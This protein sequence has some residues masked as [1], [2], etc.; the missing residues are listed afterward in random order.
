MWIYPNLKRLFSDIWIHLGNCIVMYARINAQ[1][2]NSSWYEETSG[3]V[4]NNLH[5]QHAVHERDPV[6]DPR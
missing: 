2:L 5:L 3:V 4:T 1:L 6:I